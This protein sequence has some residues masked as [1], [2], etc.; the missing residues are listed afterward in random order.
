[1]G[2]TAIV[3]GEQAEHKRRKARMDVAAPMTRGAKPAS[4]S[5]TT[6]NG[7]GLPWTQLTPRSTRRRFYFARGSFLLRGREEKKDEIVVELHPVDTTEKT[8]APLVLLPAFPSRSST[9]SKL[10]AFVFRGGSVLCCCSAVICDAV[11]DAYCCA[12][13]WW[14][15]MCIRFS[16]HTWRRYMG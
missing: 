3:A 2:D 15:A 6:Q 9:G 13:C 7:R 1:M 11:I 4:C 16:I 8:N 5:S 12:L 14:A 10:L